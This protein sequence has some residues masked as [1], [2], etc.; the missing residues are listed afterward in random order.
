MHKI[1]ALGLV[2][3]GRTK[4]GRTTW[5]SHPPIGG[6]LAIEGRM[7]LV[8]VCRPYILGGDLATKR[9]GSGAGT[10]ITAALFN[11][12]GCVK[13]AMVDRLHVFD[14]LA[15]DPGCRRQP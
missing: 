7:I 1:A 6:P 11:Q 13:E 2:H 8:G 5:R 15:I 3:I 4:A 10:V 9:C 12:S 14:R